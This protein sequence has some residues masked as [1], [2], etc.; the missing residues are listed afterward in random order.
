[1]ITDIAGITA[2]T[3]IVAIDPGT[4]ASGW[5]AWKK[6]L[7]IISNT[8]ENR[9]LRYML[10]SGTLVGRQDKID[11]VPVE[12]TWPSRPHEHALRVVCE[13][14]TSYGATVGRSTFETIFW[15]GMFL[16]V[17]YP[18]QKLPRKAPWGPNPD[19]Y[20]FQDDPWYE[21]VCN[22]LLHRN[23][24]TDAQINSVLKHRF[25][26]TGGGKTPSV[27]TKAQPGPLYG[28]KGHEWSALAVAVTFVEQF[29]KERVR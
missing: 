23:T 25:P 6:P 16:S 20:G 1:M 26:Q 18:Y 29:G 4:I 17:G 28:I 10:K 13:Y 24:G 3:T 19:Q 14:I 22:H 2:P 8:T 5:I 9:Q 11:L 27:G 21:G 7:W 12:S 15:T